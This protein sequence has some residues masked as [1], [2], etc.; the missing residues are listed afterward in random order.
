MIGTYGS[1]VRWF[2]VM[3]HCMLDTQTHPVCVYFDSMRCRIR[4]RQDTKE[5][6][7]VIVTHRH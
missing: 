6:T 4:A 3:C 7:C 5:S 1:C 2:R